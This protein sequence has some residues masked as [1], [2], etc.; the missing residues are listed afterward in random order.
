[1]A[2][3]SR[4]RAV[5]G[6]IMTD[7]SERTAGRAPNVADFIDAEYITLPPEGLS[8]GPLRGE[9]SLSDSLKSPAL[10]IGSVAA[11]SVGMDMLRRP[12]APAAPGK[13]AR[14]GPLFWMAGVGF[15][16][17][18]FWVSGGHA[19][20]RGVPFIGTEAPPSALSISGI[21]SRVDTSGVRPI[22]FVDGE[23]ANDGAAVEHLPPLAIAVTGND[24]RV[25]RYR[26]GTSGRPLASGETFAFSSR[27]DVPKNGVKTVSVAFAE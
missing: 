27:L 8:S 9:P 26:L 7:P 17:A 6:E 2:D 22:L 18:A 21:T 4:P 12:D 10:S 16:A 20:V 23:A 19:L 15:A 13:P 3:G 1:M 25:T 14:G 24:G 5:S 11:P